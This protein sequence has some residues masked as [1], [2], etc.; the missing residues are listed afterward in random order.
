MGEKFSF[1]EIIHVAP[2]GVWMWEVGW[3]EPFKF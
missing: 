1:S 2:Q 3:I